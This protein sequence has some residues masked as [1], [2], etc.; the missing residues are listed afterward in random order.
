MLHGHGPSAILFGLGILLS[1]CLTA[2]QIRLNTILR[3]TAAPRDDRWH[4][5]ATATSGGVA[6]F[7]A[8]ATLYLYF[9]RGQQSGIATAA[10]AMWA[11]GLLD[12]LVRLQPR[13]KFAGQSLL[14][15][16]VVAS[17]ITFH[18]FPSTVLNMALSLLWLVG[19]TNAFNLI[20]NMDG[21]CAGVTVIIGASLFARQAAAG[22]WPEANLCL[23]VC[24]AFAG[25]LLLNRKPAKIFMGD[26][27]SMLAGFTLAALSL[28]SPLSQAPSPMG[29]ILSAAAVFSYPIFD[30]V[31]V[32]ILRRSAGRPISVGGRDH[33]SHRLVLLGL[34]EACAVALLWGLAALGCSISLVFS[35]NLA[36]L[37]ALT[38]FLFVALVRFGKYLARVQIGPAMPARSAEA[39]DSV[40]ADVGARQKHQ[41]TALR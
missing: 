29:G 24:A 25:F 13:I 15:S 32:S 22:F 21:L 30:T 41:A 26:C 17:G 23:I 36:A 31:L 4:R 8:T 2:V 14:C 16:C 5:N 11:F 1:L 40:A 28:S 18:V 33:S 39:N 37:A 3:L 20:D 19:V 7:C 9:S 27:G 6:V 12:D 10:L 35:G 34:S 38:C